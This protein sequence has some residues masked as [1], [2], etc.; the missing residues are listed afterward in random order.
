MLDSQI[1]GFTEGTFTP[2]SEFISNI[3]I[4]TQMT[5]DLEIM[6]AKE[7]YEYDVGPA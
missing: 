7:T 2:F 3:E 6:I 1:L 4:Y 5:I